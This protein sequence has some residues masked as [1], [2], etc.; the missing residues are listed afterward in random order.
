MKHTVALT[1]S[2]LL[3]I[4][5]FAVHLT[6]DIVR[7]FEPG[8]LTNLNAVLIFVVWLYA[9][10]VLAGRRS[11]YSILLLASFLSTGV[12]ILH[13]RGAG[14]A[15]IAKTDGGFFFV[16]TLLALGVTALFSLIL[17]IQGLWSLRRGR[18]GSV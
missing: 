13:F 15:R 1:V 8:T 12:P 18:A 2:S 7:G 16:L 4:V 14:V 9:T 5:L 3:S 10:L 11:G 17:S 6:H